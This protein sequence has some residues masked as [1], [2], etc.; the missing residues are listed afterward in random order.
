MVRETTL[1]PDDFI[2]PLFVRP[3]SDIQK[4]I[5]SMPGQHQWSVD[6][7]VGEV[8]AAAARGIPAVM[9]FGIPDAKDSC[10][11]DNFDRDGIVPTAIRAIKDAVPD[12]IVLSDMCFCEYTDHGHCGIINQPGDVHYTP[13]LPEGYLLN[14]PTLEL[15][16]RAS[17]VHAAAGA[18]IIAP[19]GM[20]DGMVGAIRAALDADGFDHVSI[21]S[22]AAKYASGFYGPFRD[23]AES[24]PQFG[25]RS[26]YQMDP[27]NRREALK[28]V[29]LDVAEGADMLMVKPALPYLDILA[30]MRA[31]YDL[32]TAA[33]QV[34]GEYAMMHAA[35]ERSWLD[36]ERCALESLL[37]IKRAGADMI[38][39]YF[40]KDAVEWLQT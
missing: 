39:T 15:L 30:A 19:S 24:P 4:P 35:A 16:G 2:Y 12:M 9:L 31:G 5:A 27:A 26:A 22:Y 18:D 37:S 7:L 17:A 34:S 21:M 38:L 32:P 1:S 3:G 14:D 13:H 28:E 6:R 10:G 33:Y 8:K 20:I 11:S 23:A 29:A 36:L 40:A 25:D